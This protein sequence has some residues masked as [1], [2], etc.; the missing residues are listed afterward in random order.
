MLT[1]V[2]VPQWQGSLSPTAP[3]L[4]EGAGRLAAMVPAGRHIRVETGDTLAD[5]AQRVRRA[6]PDDGFIVTVGGDCGV[7]LAPVT[8]ALRRYGDRLTLVWFDAH[9]DMNTPATSPSGAFHGMILRTLQGD[10]PPDLVP[11][12]ALPPA[13]VALAGTRCLDPA[14]AEYIE[15]AGIGGLST[16]DKDA[17]LYIHV[18]LDVLDGITSVG[19]PEPG[20]LSPQ[21]LTAAIAE[22]AARHEVVGMGITEYAPADPRDEQMLRRLVPELVRL[23]STSRPWQIERR[24]VNAWPARHIEERDGWLLRHTPGVTR[25]RSNSALPLFGATPSIPAL[26]D[27]Y[28]ERAMPVVVQVDPAEHHLDLDGHLAARGY[29]LAARTLVMTGDA[30]TVLTIAADL[31]GI[32]RVDDQARWPAVFETVTGSVDDLSVINR[33]EPESILLTK[34]AQGLGLAVTEDGWTGIYCMATHPDH[35]R[36]GVATAVLA[37]AVRCSLDRGAPQLYL[38]VEEDNLPARALYEGLGFTQSHS[39]HYRV[40]S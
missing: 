28:A 36:K 7:E 5:T 1:V 32:E 14:E 39:Y 29:D 16:I 8:R 15:R 19:Y 3:R 37:A 17:V 25:R 23:C 35:R 21:A 38:Q 40:R 20:G 9:G 33:I 24:A 2:E 11:S 22:L 6:F 18:D 10:G 34:P 30:A 4:V 13:Q 26:E 31:G 12:L 27:F